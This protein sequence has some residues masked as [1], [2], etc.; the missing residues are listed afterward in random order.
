VRAFAADLLTPEQSAAAAEAWLANYRDLAA[1]AEPALR[2][3]QQLEWLHRLERETENLAR[4]TRVLF[5][6]RDLDDAAAYFWDLYL[7]LWIGGYLGVVR[8]WADELL[9]IAEREQVPIAARTR[10]IAEYFANAVRFWQEPGYDVV[11]GLTLSRDLFIEAGDEHGAAVAGI[12]IGLAQLSRAEPDVPAAVGA[13]EASRAGFAHE[14]DAWGQAMVLNVLGRVNMAGGDM[15]AARELFEESLR[16]ATA[17]GERLGIVIAMNS[18]GWT[19][20][21]SGDVVGGE[22]DFAQSLD[23]SLALRHDEGIAYG[24]EAYAGLRALQSDP[25]AAGRLLGAAQRLRRRKGLVNL[26][27]FE[28]YMIPVGALRAAGAGDALDA[29]IAEGLELT[30]AEVLDHV[31]S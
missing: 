11:P 25:V 30:V 20:L 22:D 3:A 6:R 27:T 19:R 7:Y 26:G 2:G 13:L 24:L 31:R 29:A 28:W 16:L 18:R 23:L 10:A 21:L 5:D 4:V 9:E 8:N 15:A 14:G 17:Q 1:E 12:S